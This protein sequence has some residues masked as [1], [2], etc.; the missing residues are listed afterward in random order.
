MKVIKI[1]DKSQYG[2][3]TVQEYLSDELASDSE[4]EKRLYRSER[5]AEKKAKDAVCHSR[6][7]TLY[8][9]DNF[10]LIIF[11]IHFLSFNLIP[12]LVS[13]CMFFLSRSRS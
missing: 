8:Q 9:A 13:I 12:Y 3:A 5:R 4:D 6:S 2:W 1:A 10:L 7:S 11:L